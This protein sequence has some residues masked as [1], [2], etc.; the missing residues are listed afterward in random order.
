[1]KLIIEVESSSA[2]SIL[3]F[4]ALFKKKKNEETFRRST[5]SESV[6]RTIF[7]N[8]TSGARRAKNRSLLG[9]RATTW[10]RLIPSKTSREEGR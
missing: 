3:T 7:R 10:A 5:P 4:I 6:H 1:M 9:P 8:P 2:A